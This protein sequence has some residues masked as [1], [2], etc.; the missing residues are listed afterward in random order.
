MPFCAA[1]SF[2]PADGLDDIALDV[3]EAGVRSTGAEG[4]SVGYDFGLASCSAA[5]GASGAAEA[6]A[7]AVVMLYMEDSVRY[8]GTIGIG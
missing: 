4:A 2:P 1:L 5:G 3:A 8:C 6:D 7:T